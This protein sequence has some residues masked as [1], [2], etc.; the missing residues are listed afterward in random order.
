M[1]SVMRGR[2]VA[3]VVASR[4]PDYQPGEQVMATVGWQDYA[5]TTPAREGVL[6]TPKITD[7]SV[8][9]ALHLGILGAAGLTAYFGLMDVGDL[10]PGNTVVIS[11]AAGG[12]GS[13]AIQIAQ[14]LGA[15]TV[16]GIAGGAE[17]CAWMMDHLGASAAIDYKN[18]NIGT[19]LDEHC[20]NGIDVFFDNVGGEQLECAL[21]RLK[22]GARVAIC[23]FIAT[24]YTQTPTGPKNYIYLVRCRA[25]M[26][27]FFVFDYERQFE[28]ASRQLKEWY[29]A[30]KLRPCEDVIDGLENMPL[31][32][33]G[34]F[35][36]SNRGVSICRVGEATQRP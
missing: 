18:E 21:E 35:T 32:L 26:Q 25:R 6:S 8:P 16:V 29:A 28:A 13:C 10:N 11:A 33:Q 19:A 36:G 5:V 15:G 17:K 9:P 31:A 20:P 22:L 24:D 14:C 23:G 7:T 34:L 4:H 30:G 12:V 1:G 2:G 3:E 27:G